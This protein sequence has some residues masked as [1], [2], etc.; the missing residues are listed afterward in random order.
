MG[1]EPLGEI[2]VDHEPPIPV[3]VEETLP[4]GLQAGVVVVAPQ[5]NLHQPQPLLAEP[6]LNQ[7][8]NLA[9][10]HQFPSSE[11]LQADLATSEPNQDPPS[12][13]TSYPPE[14]AN[15]RFLKMRGESVFSFLFFF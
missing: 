7:Q 2:P 13:G 10:V 6:V 5:N 1:E 15:P 8:G 9:F 3:I 11:E 14:N 4:V 12:P